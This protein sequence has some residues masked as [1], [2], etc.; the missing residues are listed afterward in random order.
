YKS[1]QD[2]RNPT[3]VFR[4]P[5]KQEHTSL[6]TT[7]FSDYIFNALVLGVY[8]WNIKPSR[9]SRIRQPSAVMILADAYDTKDINVPVCMIWQTN[10]LVAT[11]GWLGY[12]QHKLTV[13]VLYG[14]V[15]VSPSKFPGETA[16][17]VLNPN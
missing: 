5:S 2:P 6:G 12:T 14:D 13:N 17:I 4:C 9:R 3:S 10:Q 1:V 8:E 16:S 7:I 15:H 11:S